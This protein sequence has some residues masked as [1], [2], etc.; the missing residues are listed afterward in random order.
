MPEPRRR[1]RHVEVLHA[2]RAQRI[3]HRVHQSRE[4][5][6]GARFAN[7][8]RTE[9]IGLRRHRTRDEVGLAH[10]A[11]AWHRVIHETAAEQLS[12]L[13][14]VDGLLAGRLARTLHDAAVQLPFDDRGVHHVAHVVAGDVGHGLRLSGL[15]I[16]FHLR[17]MAAIG[18][19]RPELPLEI[20]IERM[21]SRARMARGER[22]ERDCAAGTPG[23]KETVVEID[24]FPGGAQRG[25]GQWYRL[26]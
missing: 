18:I 9:R 19:G 6:G 14:I 24:V 15:R 25:G 10:D 13:G 23:V 7:T 12:A 22:R 16:D 5:T 21:W 11:R 17:D 1:C 8:F 20:E 2:S 4:R 3:E 26:L